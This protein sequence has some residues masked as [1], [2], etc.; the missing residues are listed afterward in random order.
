MSE[1]LLSLVKKRRYRDISVVDICQRAMVH[2]TTFYTHFADKDALFRYVLEEEMEKVAARRKPLPADCGLWESIQEELRVALHFCNTHRDIYLSG[3][4]GG[5]Y[6]EIRAVED[7]ITG[8]IK[9]I[10][11]DKSPTETSL[12]AELTGRFYAGSLMNVTRWW[13]VEQ[14]PLAEEELLD[15]M[16][17]L[18]PTSWEGR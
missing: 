17:R 1:A 10:V 8:K 12:M 2:R 13:I 14:I 18:L 11:L 16:E 5:G 3:L 6:G 9:R 4:A 15:L 7:R